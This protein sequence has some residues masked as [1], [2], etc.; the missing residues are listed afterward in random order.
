MEKRTTDEV[1]ELRKK[2]QAASQDA[3]RIAEA[4]E[5]LQKQAQAASQLADPRQRDDA[6]RKLALD[7]D[8]LRRRTEDLA[9]RLTRDKEHRSAEAARQAADMMAEARDELD[10]GRLPVDRQDQALDKLDETLDRLESQDK[11]EQEQ[12][13]REQREELMDRLA[14]IRDRQAAILTEA[15]RI[16]NA[17]LAAE[18]WSRGQLRSYT[19]LEPSQA[20]VADEVRSLTEKHL[21]D[22]PVFHRLA[23]QAAQAMDR[24]A[25]KSAERVQDTIP[26]ESLDVDAETAADER[27]RGPMRTALR[28]LDQIL[29]AVTAQ[30]NPSQPATPPDAADRPP[31]ND[32]GSGPAGAARPSIPPLAQLKALRAV[33]AEVNERTAAFAKAHPHSE[34]LTDDDRDELK[35]LEQIQREIAELFEALAPLLQPSGWSFP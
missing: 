33:Q 29:E 7:Q 15:E 5:E 17:V 4:Q 6:L 3:E 2:R 16:H 26:G 24:A 10:Q 13:S 32:D 28:R 35:E 9:E 22:M 1:E 18:E 31:G 12:L 20:S 14:A 30:E 11:Q 34:P 27:V 19:E 23:N 8:K 21:S 25:R